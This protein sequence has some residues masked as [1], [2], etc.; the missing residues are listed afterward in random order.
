MSLD[1]PPRKPPQADRPYSIALERHYSVGEVAKL[2]H[3]SEKV[4][5]KLFEGE[6]GVL[7]W[8]QPATRSRRSYLTIRIPESVLIRV[9]QRRQ[10]ASLGARSN[11][12][13]LHHSLLSEGRLGP[14]VKLRPSIADTGR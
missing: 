14:L 3:L 1:L 7:T 12:D 13:R 4:V 5:R 10:A 9:H 2:W 8:G 6:D 11:E